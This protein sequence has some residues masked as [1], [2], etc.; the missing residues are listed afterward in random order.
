MSRITTDPIDPAYRDI[1]DQFA[2]GR[3]EDSEKALQQALHRDGAQPSLLRLLG[4][5]LEAANQFDQAYALYKQLTASVE[6]DADLYA[7]LARCC[8]LLGRPYEANA[9]TKP[10]TESLDQPETGRC[11]SAAVLTW[12]GKWSEARAALEINYG[13][14]DAP[15]RDDALCRRQ[16]CDNML[17]FREHR[18]D[19]FAALAAVRCPLHVRKACVPGGGAGIDSYRGNGWVRVFTQMPKV[20]VVPADKQ[21]LLCAF[22][23]AFGSL[24]AWP[25]LKQCYHTRPLN[26]YLTQQQ[27][28][29][30]FES[31]PQ[32]VHAMAMLEDLRLYIADSRVHWYLG[33]GG[34]ERF[35]RDL[36][37]DGQLLVPTASI[38]EH[39]GAQD[40]IT[41]L[42]L[43][44][45]EATDRLTTELKAYYQALPADH[46]R[47]V[48]SQTLNR[49]PR[50]Y[51]LTTRFSTVL[52]FVTADMERAFRRLGWE[53]RVCIEADD[54]RVHTE[55][56][57][58][59]DLSEFKPD[60]FFTLDHLRYEWMFRSF[61]ELYHI[62]WIQDQMAN[63]YCTKAGESLGP[64]DFVLVLGCG[65]DLMHR[66]HYPRRCL[67]HM[68]FSTNLDSCVTADRPDLSAYSL[69]DVA[70]ASN[71]GQTAEAALVSVLAAAGPD[72]PAE[73]QEIATPYL[74]AI[75]DRYAAGSPLY[76]DV[77]YR[78][79]L[80]ETETKTGVLLPSEPWRTLLVRTCRLHVGGVVHRQQ[81][82]RWLKEA[83]VN[84][85]V[86]GREWDRHPEFAPH[87]K[88]LITD[89]NVMNAIFRATP[90]NL[91]I[92]QYTNSHIRFW[93]G[94]AAGGFFLVRACPLDSGRAA[95]ENVLALLRRESGRT[96]TDVL[97]TTRLDTLETVL[98][99]SH[100][101]ENI[102]GHS[103]IDDYAI[104]VFTMTLECATWTEKL[105][106]LAGKIQ[107][108][109]REQC[110]EMIHRYLKDP[111]ARE[112][113][114]AC[115]RDVL[116]DQTY[117]AN[118]RRA[119]ATIRDRIG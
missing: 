86:Y 104:D 94:L 85:G 51:L 80:Q 16:L 99:R 60:V 72:C 7:R 93:N 61:P 78:N 76:E 26:M 71:H 38:G 88:G 97:R 47:R 54:A 24:T 9:L 98:F 32:A 112:A 83:G 64:R 50:V 20:P 116:Q 114:M 3:F 115:A 53:T 84:F 70:F 42:N 15:W 73:Y 1:A 2:A 46:G 8:L 74:R 91:Q 17:T 45:D 113:V 109:T 82:L 4:Y 25:L 65:A 59:K 110:L 14:L 106:D 63:L 31:D 27:A 43:S 119:L 90:I 103:Q 12:Q 79:L 81:V 57:I 49:P 41:A 67:V 29:Y 101:E 102:P 107:F 100:F 111:A 62:C 75:L 30:F 22:A 36:E 89:G 66:Y 10:L 28:L 52:Q 5:H 95:A 13:Q 48:F 56:A 105:G 118:L 18:G 77:Q 87:A 55:Y 21:D 34:A 6:P 96:Y 35:Q 44:R 117:E 108:E 40:A 11:I 68:P 39:A 69:P 23:L 92:S 37:N 19:T 58:L 33:A